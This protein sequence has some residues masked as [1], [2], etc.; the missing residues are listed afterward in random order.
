VNYYGQFHTERLQKLV[1]DY[2]RIIIDQTQAYFQMPIEGTDT[3]YCCRKFFGVTDGAFLYTNTF[4]DEAIPQDESFNRMKF[5]FGRFERGATE[6]YKDYVLNEEIFANEPIKEMSKIT[7]NMLH[8]IDYNKVKM[9]RTQ[10]FEYLHKR[11][12][13]INNLHLVIPEGAFMY[14]L[15]IPNGQVIRKLMQKENIYIPILWPNVLKQCK[16]NEL[17]Y[18]MA[19]NILPL[20]VDQRYSY[21]EMDVMATCIEQN[22]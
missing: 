18:D 16:K 15:Y 6:F 21:P 11:L 12:Q 4:L 14:P 22:L 2:Q 9:K 20:P 7:Q 8:G 13:K 5:L 1:L 3:I 17:E 19:C 10:N